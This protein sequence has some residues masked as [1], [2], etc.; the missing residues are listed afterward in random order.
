MNDHRSGGVTWTLF[1]GGLWLL[2]FRALWVDWETNP[3]YGYGWLVPLLMAGLFW[4]R[5]ETRPPPTPVARPVPLIRVAAGLI[6]LLFPILLV[7][8][9]NPEWRRPMWA[10]GVLTVSVTLLALARRGGG[11]WARHFAFPVAFA[12]VAIPWPSVPEAALTQGL[13][14]GVAVATSSLL[15]WLGVPTLRHGNALELAGGM[16]GIEEACSGIRSL[17]STVMLALF[18]G[19]FHRLNARRRGWL[20][21]A[22]FAIAVVGNLGRTLFLT[23]Q[24]ATN[25]TSGLERWHDPAGYAASGVGFATIWLISAWLN[26]RS[27]EAAQV[28]AENRADSRPE[29]EPIP[30]QPLGTAT[31][32]TRELSDKDLRQGAAREAGPTPPRR[33]SGSLATA[34][35]AWLVCCLVGV[36][37]WY[38]FHEAGLVTRP[39]WRVVWPAGSRPLALTE[40]E[41]KILRCDQY[42]AR[43]WEDPSGIRWVM[44]H[45]GWS[46]GRTSAQLAKGHTPAGCFPATGMRLEAGLGEHP[47]RVGPV[48]FR[49]HQYQFTSETGP[50]FAFWGVYEEKQGRGEPSW[51]EDGSV[52]SRLQA[53]RYGKRNLGQQVLEVALVNV[54]NEATA[55]AHFAQMLDQVI[56]PV[57]AGNGNSGN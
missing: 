6:L 47:F 12:L 41:L 37:G 28:P 21:L 34:G 9:A 35:L 22:G 52:S 48:R 50:V 53:V 2:L 39:R 15:P 38:R 25:G 23:W 24:V 57:P 31:A 11:A 42:E 20:L 43:A 40:R 10:Q 30:G 49:F 19:E 5:W 45:L 3:Q 14:R 56:R 7:A 46:P 27:A 44:H 13:S 1:W 16:V 26:R 55:R 32:Q 36:E 54:A 8:E 33:R 17:Q 4:R 51:R 18:F 29:E